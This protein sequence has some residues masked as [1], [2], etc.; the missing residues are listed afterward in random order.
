MIRFTHSNEQALHCSMKVDGKEKILLT[1]SFYCICL[2]SIRY[3]SLS[4]SKY[5]RYYTGHTK[6]YRSFRVIFK[7]KFVYV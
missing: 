5:I 7:K 6:K 2:D 3:L 1:F 4:D